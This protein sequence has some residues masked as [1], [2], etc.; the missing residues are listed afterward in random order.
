RS[1]PPVSAPL[2]RTAAGHTSPSRADPSPSA[3]APF[4]RGSRSARGRKVH[5][6]SAEGLLAGAHAQQADGGSRANL[7]RSEE[8]DEP[9]VRAHLDEP[10]R[11]GSTRR[12]PGEK[13]EQE[14]RHHSDAQAN[15]HEATDSD[16]ACGADREGSTDQQPGEEP[17]QHRNEQAEEPPGELARREC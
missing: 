11:A 8:A 17:G 5:P 9:R 10:T 4:E 7:E 3:G 13:A 6:R 16:R 12:E 15:T 1:R 14:A 2:N